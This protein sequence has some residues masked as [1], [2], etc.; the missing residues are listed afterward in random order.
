MQ[1]SAKATVGTWLLIGAGAA[2]DRSRLTLAERVL[3]AEPSA[4]RADE[5]R[6]DWVDIPGCEVQAVGLGAED[7]PG[8]L[9]V[10]NAPAF[11]SLHAPLPAL[12][13]LFP[14]LRSLAIQ[15]VRVVTPKTLLAGRTP[16]PAPLRIRID[17]P[18]SE[19]DILRGLAAADILDECDLLELRCGNAAYHEGATDRA[20]LESWLA[21]RSLVCTQVD[22]TDPDWPVLTF[23]PDRARREAE[24]LHRRIAALEAALQARGA[25]L[26]AQEAALGD[27]TGKA[28]WRQGR[29]GELEA[30]LK[31]QT[32]AAAQATE[33]AQRRLAADLKGAQAALSARTEERDK[34]LQLA[35]SRAA[36][37]KARDA[38]FKA[39]EDMASWRDGR[40]AALEAE[41]ERQTAAAA[42]AAARAAALQDRLDA[43]DAAFRALED[44]ANRRRDRIGELEAELRKQADLAAGPSAREADL[45]HRLALSRDDLRRAEGQIALITDLLLRGE[46]L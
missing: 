3:I 35:E 1:D 25:A 10:M 46:I 5:L 32:A 40:I 20:G 33:A 13:A 37:L 24:A 30:E 16:L 18:G 34:A 23:S 17:A 31:K 28:H 7:G 4:E 14:G 8:R 29:I 9:H 39:L 45:E 21:G 36:A 27:M 43:R 41:L 44:R 12:M 19:M 2:Q 11:S 42:E 22:D 38:G 6:R 26:A 15:D